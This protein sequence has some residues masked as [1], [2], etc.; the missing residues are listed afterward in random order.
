MPNSF[1]KFGNNRDFSLIENYLCPISATLIINSA[2]NKINLPTI[3]ELLSLKEIV[4]NQQQSI[5]ELIDNEKTKLKEQI[6]LLKQNNENII[7]LIESNNLNDEETLNKIKQI[8]ADIQD[9]VLK[10]I[11]QIKKINDEQKEQIKELE[12]DSLESK[13]NIQHLDRRIKNTN[14]TVSND[15]LKIINFIKP[16]CAANGWAHPYGT[17]IAPDWIEIKSET[18]NIIKLEKDGLT[19]HKKGVGWKKLNIETLVFISYKFQF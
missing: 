8:K 13:E 14:I 7:K 17:R 6:D 18:E 11:T 9:T 15:D 12:H 2:W 3:D 5:L 19:I 10:E 16:F 1:N 4:D